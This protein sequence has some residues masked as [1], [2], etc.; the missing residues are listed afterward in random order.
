LNVIVAFMVVQGDSFQ[1]GIADTILSYAS[2]YPAVGT[3]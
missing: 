3:P 1:T 2:N